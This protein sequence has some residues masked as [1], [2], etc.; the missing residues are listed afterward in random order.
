MLRDRKGARALTASNVEQARFGTET[1][2]AGKLDRK[3][4]SAGMK[5]F[6]EQ[7]PRGVAPVEQ[8]AALLDVGRRLSLR[9]DHWAEFRPVGVGFDGARM[10]K[11]TGC[12]WYGSPA[13]FA[14]RRSGSMAS[15][16][17]R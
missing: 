6:T 3:L 15:S 8:R 10:S 16:C 4:R 2:H 9:L 11:C 12:G 13:R 7:I 17:A 5:A 1:E 14:R